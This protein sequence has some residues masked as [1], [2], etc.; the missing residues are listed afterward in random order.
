L[1][2]ELPVV[3]RAE[4]IVP[5]YCMPLR[6]LEG[7]RAL[8]TWSYA[9]QNQEI[10]GCGPLRVWDADTRTVLQIGGSDHSLSAGDVS[11]S[12]QW[13]A[14]SPVSV[15]VAVLVHDARTGEKVLEV[16][17]S[18]AQSRVIAVAFSP[19]DMQIAFAEGTGHEFRV[20]VWDT[21][22][23]KETFAFPYPVMKH[24]DSF[25][26]GGRLLTWSLD[27]A[28]LAV[29]ETGGRDEPGIPTVHVRRLSSGEIVRTFQGPARSVIADMRFS[30]DS[31]QL[32]ATFC[33]PN[34]PLYNASCWNVESGHETF[35]VAGD[36]ALIRPLGPWVIDSGRGAEPKGVRVFGF[37]EP[38]PQLAFPLKPE[39]G[40]VSG[41][42][43]FDHRTLAVGAEGPDR[44]TKWLL[45]QGWSVPWRQ[46]EYWEIRFVDGFTHREISKLKP[47]R[48]PNVDTRATWAEFS[49][50]GRLFAVN[51]GQTLRL[52]DYPPRK[53]LRWF[54]AGSALLALPIALA[55]W[56]RSRKL[57]AA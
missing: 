52:Y 3:P 29:G 46:E 56:R 23:N 21:Q 2:W 9:V 37:A 16:P 55:A 40:V 10:V 42:L 34:R 11:R 50:D 49:P 1:W 27:G 30:P 33:T 28:Y 41:G 20:R 57:R 5:E 45:A 54:P 4:W 12:G 36:D 25:G 8:V 32:A 48:V 15:D 19:D 13:I 18:I 22:T 51:D 7:R 26:F 14:E 39:E 6:F 47:M 24:S 38:T 44:L 43:A 17:R 35:S 31:K 53:S